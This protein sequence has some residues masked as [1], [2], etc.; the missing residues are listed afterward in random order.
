MKY[1]VS[2]GVSLSLLAMPGVA[3]AAGGGETRLGIGYG[4]GSVTLDDDFGN[5]LSADVTSTDLHFTHFTGESGAVIGGFY[6]KTTLD[7]FELNGQAL[8]LGSADADILGVR[9]G[10]RGGR[11]GTAQPVVLFLAQRVDPDE[12]DSN[13]ALGVQVGMERTG[14]SSRF[15][16]NGS[17]LNDDDGHTLSFG[18]N[19]TLFATE[20]FGFSLGAG[21]A[22]GE[23][24]I[25]GEK[26]DTEEYGIRA[27][28]E[29][30]FR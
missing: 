1:L 8:N 13:T 26:L 28:V 18:A 6:G 25:F 29:L 11:Y 19:V 16:L 20:Q 14:Q 9:A 7:E 21:Y 3:T 4:F 10:Y 5:E 17:F 30:R 22:F 23:T 2:T 12:G 24:E 15:G 27:G